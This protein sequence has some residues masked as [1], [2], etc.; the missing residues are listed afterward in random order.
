MYYI[1][2]YYITKLTIELPI[3]FL[4]V[5]LSSSTLFLIVGLENTARFWIYYSTPFNLLSSFFFA[6]LARRLHD[7]S[8]D[9]SH[10]QVTVLCYPSRR[11]GHVSHN[12]LWRTGSQLTDDSRFCQL[13]TVCHSPSLRLQYPDKK[14]FINRGVSIYGR[15]SKNSI[16]FRVEGLGC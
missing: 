2:V 5:I 8:G 7:R 15:R 14:A 10:V 1:S 9:R 6:G 11:Y 3:M 13:V 12:D 16:I 4:S